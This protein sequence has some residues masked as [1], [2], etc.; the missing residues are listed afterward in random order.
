MRQPPNRPRRR[1]RL[2]APWLAAIVIAAAGAVVF[3]TPSNAA[4]R[5]PAA[6]AGKFI[7]Y[8]GN[9]GLL[10]NNSATCTSGSDATYR[11]LAASEFNQITAENV[12]K[13]ETTEPNDNQFNFTAGDG[14]VAFANANNQVVHGH[15]LVWHSQTP[16]WVQGLS[17]TAM[18]T[19]MQDHIT[20]L[21]ARWPNIPSWDVVN[22]AIGDNGALRTSF[23]LNTMGQGYIADAFRF[24][25]AA[26]A[27]AD[28]CIND[29]SVE[30]TGTKSNLLFSTVQGLLNQGV[31]ITCVGFQSHLIVGQVPSSFQSNLQRFANLGLKV[32]ITELD[33]RIPLPADNN[34]LTQQANDYRTVV[35]VC[36]AVAACSGIT[37]WGID[38]G[39][40]WLP[41]SCCPEGAPLLWNASYQ[42]KPAYAAVNAAF[43]GGTITT[44][45]S[46]PP[47]STTTTTT[48]RPPTSTTT[49][50]TTT[51][52]GQPG[53]CSASYALIGQ[54]PDGFQ[55]EVRVTNNGSTSTTGWTVVMTM[56][57]SQ[58]VT[59]IWG[60]R[61]A[62]LPANSPVTVTQE[63]WTAVIPPN[64]GSVTFGFIGGK[65]LNS[66]A[67]NPTFTCSR[68]P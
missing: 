19:A 12:M 21:M 37:L 13:W 3:S 6:S 42:Q 29:Y 49:T 46:R 16:G 38:D 45:T 60:G 27:D 61:V 8:A 67:V 40:S 62:S 11:G 66:T 58:R 28:L 30:G 9:A 10:C 7:G 26:D 52:T 14:I 50:T 65:P 56:G 36:R 17:A 39:H 33:I 31:P 5:T 47:T 2:V 23:W 22:E 1:L 55:G 35:N 32:R 41:N 4:L 63:T 44:T 15:T 25:R 24:A 53:S 51:S 68:T 64:G 43:G 18:R 48:S 54:W 57:N 20:R 59:Q 34:E